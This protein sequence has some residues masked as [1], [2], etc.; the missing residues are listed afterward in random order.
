MSS[1]TYNS[2]DL[3][4]QRMT[5]VDMLDLAEM[6]QKLPFQKELDV[7]GK[8]FLS[9]HAMTSDPLV[10]Q[11]NDYYMMGNYDL[12]AF[13]WRESMVTFRYAVTLLQAM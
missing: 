11:A 6:I 8:K 1:Y 4:K 3:L 7:D 5:E 9:A 10:W 13:F 12:D 2:F